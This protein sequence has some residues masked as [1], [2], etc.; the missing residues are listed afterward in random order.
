MLS[1][2]SAE[3]IAN[4]RDLFKLVDWVVNQ[5][6]HSRISIYFYEHQ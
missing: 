3:M 1:N 6:Q 2:E 5:G 4:W